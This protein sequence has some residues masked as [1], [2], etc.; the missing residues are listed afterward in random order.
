METLTKTWRPLELL[1]LILAPLAVS[2]TC[3]YGGDCDTQSL[4]SCICGILFVVLCAKGKWYAFLFGIIHCFIYGL[5]SWDATLYGDAILKFGYSI[6]MHIAGI[7]LWYRNT[8]RRTMEV[9]HRNL[10]GWGKFLIAFIIGCATYLLGN[11][12]ALLGDKLPYIDAF[13]TVASIHGAYLMVTRRAE[14]WTI[15]IIINIVSIYMWLMRYMD[16]GDNLG[17]LVMWVIWT[18]NSVYGW[19]KWNKY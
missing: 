4:L 10:D 2:L 1:W 12:L 7:F 17:T 3:V 6:P 13:T 18:I 9:I 8:S 5:I 19:F 11:V 14:Q 16:T 15:F